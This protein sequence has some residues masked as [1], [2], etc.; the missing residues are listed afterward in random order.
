M[1]KENVPDCKEQLVVAEKLLAQLKAKSNLNN[2][3]VARQLEQL[4]RAMRE[5]KDGGFEEDL[6]QEMLRADQLL[7]KLRKLEEMKAK[8]S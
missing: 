4:E 6:K 3:L 5:V 2:A 8:V 1:K 7:G